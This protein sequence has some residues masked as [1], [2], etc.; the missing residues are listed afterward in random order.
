M[1]RRSVLALFATFVAWCIAPLKALWATARPAA[2]P[3]K[4]HPMSSSTDFLFRVH[5]PL[6]LDNKSKFFFLGPAGGAQ[7]GWYTL[8]PD[9]SGSAYIDRMDFWPTPH[10]PGNVYWPQDGSYIQTLDAASGLGLTFDG[11]TN[12]RTNCAGP[13]WAGV[14]FDFVKHDCVRFTPYAGDVLPIRPAGEPTEFFCKVQSILNNRPSI[15]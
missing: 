6:N 2:A 14:Q 12:F 10:E 8:N 13:D 3:G 7:T 9:G 11:V 4:R 1:D 15:G 5:I